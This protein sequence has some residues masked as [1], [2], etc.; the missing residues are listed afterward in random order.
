[1][2]RDPT[3]RGSWYRQPVAWLGL[4]IFVASLAGCIWMIV[5]GA[6]H[7]DE[8]VPTGVRVF[9]VP[10][11]EPIAVPASAPTDAPPEAPPEPPR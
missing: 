9:K 4:A 1:M 11:N 5:L 8:P 2:A 6:R 3:A 7:A 10:T